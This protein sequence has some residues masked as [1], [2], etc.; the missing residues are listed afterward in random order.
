MDVLVNNAATNP[1]F[2]PLIDITP[3]AWDKIMEVNVKGCLLLSQHEGLAG[4]VRE[5][6]EHDSSQTSPA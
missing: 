2:G 1:A 5:P 6:F 3:E 4:S